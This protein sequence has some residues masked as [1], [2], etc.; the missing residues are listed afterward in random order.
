MR[1]SEHWFVDTS[2]ISWILEIEKVNLFRL[3]LRIRL[4]ERCLTHLTSS[5][6]NNNRRA[7][8]ASL[9]LSKV[10]TARYHDDSS[11]HEN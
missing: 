11:Y 4:R 10:K 2:K 8:Q 7:F 6:D 1:K 5:E 9:E 3:G